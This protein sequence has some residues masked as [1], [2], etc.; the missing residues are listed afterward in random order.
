VASETTWTRLDAQALLG[1]LLPGEASNAMNLGLTTA[2]LLVGGWIVWRT[3]SGP[4][5]EGADNLSGLVIC[6]ATLACIYHATY[7]ALLLIVP[8]VGVAVGRLRTQL[9]PM[10]RMVVLALLTIPAV[11]YVSAREVM[12]RLAIEGSL[13]TA[14]TSANSIAI[15][16]V[17]VIAAGCLSAFAYRQLALGAPG[18]RLPLAD[19]Q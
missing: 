18:S 15:V 8:W 12:N 7:D 4:L 6:S 13:R 2:I 5:T 1:K 9:S 10:L 17:F 3:K 19:G 16:A 14:V 11:N